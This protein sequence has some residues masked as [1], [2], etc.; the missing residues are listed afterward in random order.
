ML[1]TYFKLSVFLFLLY[2][3]KYNLYVIGVFTRKYNIIKNT[4]KIDR[5]WHTNRGGGGWGQDKSLQ[6]QI[7]KKLSICTS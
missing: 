6:E 2:V 1:R 3:V 7:N 5:Q 4:D